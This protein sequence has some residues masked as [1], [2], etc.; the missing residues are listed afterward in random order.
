MYQLRNYQQKA[1]EFSLSRKGAIVADACGLGKTVVAIE[2]AKQS[3]SVAK[4]RC[5]VVSPKSLVEQWK[6]EIQIQ[7]P[8]IPITI[9]QRLPYDFSRLTGYVLLAYPDLKHDLTRQ[10]LQQVLWHYMII[11]E[12][13]RIKNR[14]TGRFKHVKKINRLRALAL[15]ATPMESGP[16]DLWT[17]LH[18]ASPHNFRGFWAFVTDWLDKKRSYWGGVDIS[19]EPRDP[20]AFGAFISDYM[21]QRT[22]AEVAP[23]LPERIDV[24]QHVTMT[25]KQ[26]SAYNAFKESDDIIVEHDDQEFIV[27]NVLALITKL[28][29]ISTYP[30]MLDVR[31][32]SG[33]V[34]WLREFIE[35]HPDEHIVVF[36]RFRQ[37]VL[38]LADFFD[39]DYIVGG[40]M[41]LG[42]DTT[43]FHRL[44][45]TIGAMGEG[46]NLQ[47]A[48]TA[49]FLDGHWSSIKMSH[50]I[51]RIHRMN[52]TEPKVVYQ[53]QACYED[54]MVY[55]AVQKK[56]SD[57]ELVRRY[58]SS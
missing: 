30:R 58:M 21:I 51:D 32:K 54:R 56:W 22:K 8:D 45:G 43:K 50:A 37:V 1:V 26:E 29:Q 24:T 18:F 5:L 9:A 53:L 19:T 49:I 13:H 25:E 3:R 52:I 28:Q 12:A 57:V 15:T 27:K 6:S 46:L 4:W 44:F 42:L 35:D 33:K 55:T 48:S 2:V 14:Q 10:R 7:D 34:E 41:S 17:L 38:D 40:D 31:A 36:S 20:K 16:K 23:E 11:D 47:R 39:G